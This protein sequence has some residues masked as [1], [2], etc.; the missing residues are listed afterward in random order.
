MSRQSR[1]GRM[2][3]RYWQNEVQK[4]QL[5]ADRNIESALVATMLLTIPVLK[6]SYKF[7]N[8]DIHEF[9]KWCEYFIDSYWRK[10]PGCKDHYLNDEMIRQLFIEEEHWDLLKGCAV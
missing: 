8:S 3:A 4:A 2:N 6:Q 1:Q 9:L 7:K 10:Q 5:G